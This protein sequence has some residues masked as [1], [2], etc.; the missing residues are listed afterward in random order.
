ML[1]RREILD[2]YQHRTGLDTSSFT[3]YQ[4]YGYWRLA[5]DRA[6]NLFSLLP[7]PDTDERFKSFGTAFSTW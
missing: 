2:L 5:R 6:A 3:F 1:T 7:W 4:V